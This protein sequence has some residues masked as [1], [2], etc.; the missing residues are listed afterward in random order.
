MLLLCDEV[1]ARY[2]QY[3]P[4]Y[5]RKDHLTMLSCSS[6]ACILFELQLLACLYPRLCQPWLCQPCCCS[7]SATIQNMHLCYTR[8]CAACS[9]DWQCHQR[10]WI[11][12]KMKQTA[13]DCQI[14]FALQ[15]MLSSYVCHTCAHHPNTCMCTVKHFCT[16]ADVL[17][18]FAACLDSLSVS[19]NSCSHHPGQSSIC[20]THKLNCWQ[21]QGSGSSAICKSRHLKPVE[22]T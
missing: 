12:H 5:L 13:A 6:I 4:V 14:C 18:V 3:I 16:P 10:M 2:N 7:P 20:I 1:H 8:A 22:H 17:G 15:A 9:V 21:N 11:V 19:N